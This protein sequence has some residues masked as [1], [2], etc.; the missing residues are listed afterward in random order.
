[1]KGF[2]NEFKNFAMKGNVMDLAV[3][4]IIGAAFGKITTSLVN[5]IIMPL[6][7]VM[8]GGIN[9][10]DKLVTVGNAEVAYGVF[11]QSVIEFTII[12]FVIFL[13]IKGIKSLEKKE[14]AKP[15]EEKIKEVPE[16]VQLLREIRDSMKR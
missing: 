11:I 4:V 10:K 12:A 9:F 8:M 1:M 16:E 2:F 3:A 6:F 5:N 15:E 13:L 7:G 14:Q